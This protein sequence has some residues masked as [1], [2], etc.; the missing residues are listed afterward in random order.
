[1]GPC[2]EAQTVGEL[3]IGWFR[4][5]RSFDHYV[6]IVGVTVLLTVVVLACFSL[7]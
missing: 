2:P 4:G 5:E 7:H 3:L 6:A 1:M